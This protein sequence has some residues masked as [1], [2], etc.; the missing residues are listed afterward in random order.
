MFTA[1]VLLAS[2]IT[3]QN[4]PRVQ[5]T[6]FSIEIPQKYSRQVSTKNIFLSNSVGMSSTRIGFT[7]EGKVADPV[8]FQERLWAKQ[9][10]GWSATDV[11]PDT[12]LEIG[13]AVLLHRSGTLTLRDAKRFESTLVL[14]TPDGSISA[15]VTATDAQRGVEGLA[16][17]IQ[18]LRTVQTES[19]AIATGKPSK[20]TS[21]TNS[22][23]NSGSTSTSSSN[24][25]PPTTK[26]T[27][28]KPPRT[29]PPSSPAKDVFPLVTPDEVARNARLNQIAE[30]LYPT[31]PTSLTETK[32]SALLQ[33]AVELCGFTVRNPDWQ[34]VKNP[35]KEQAIGLAV[36]T[37][38]IP[39]VATLFTQG[40]TVNYSDWTAALDQSWSKVVPNFKSGE[41]MTDFMHSGRLHPSAGYR[42]LRQFIRQLSVQSMNGVLV[43]DDNAKLDA[44]QLF[45]LTRLVTEVVLH[46]LRT[47][48]EKAKTLE[49]P[50][51]H[52]QLLASNASFTITQ[53]G[54]FSGWT[55]D[56]AS[57]ASGQY[58]N[59]V[60]DMVIETLDPLNGADKIDKLGNFADAAGAIGSIIKFICSYA[61]LTG[62]LKVLPPGNPLTRRIEGDGGEERTMQAKFMIDGS[63][64]QDFLKENRLILNSITGGTLDFDSPKTSPI[65][66][67]HQWEIEQDRFSS[68]N[69]AVTAVRGTGDFSK[70]QTDENGIT[71]L[72][73]E[74]ARRR[75]PLD[76]R[77]LIPYIRRVRVIVTPQIKE[78][79]MRQDLLDAFTTS[80]GIRGLTPG[81]VS[82]GQGG[83]NA[84]ISAMNAIF[85][86]L[87]RMNWAG[88]RYV[89]LEVKDYIEANAIATVKINFK[90]D[91][92]YQE[93]QFSYH[94]AGS[95]K[96]ESNAMLMG[97]TDFEG[98]GGYP[99][100]FTEEMLKQ[101]PPDMRAQIQAEIEKWRKEQSNPDQASLIATYLGGGEL[102]TSLNHTQDVNGVEGDGEGDSG[103]NFSA[104]QETSLNPKKPVDQNTSN[105]SLI[106]SLFKK[107]NEAEV[108]FDFGEQGIFKSRRS[109][110]GNFPPVS[111]PK[112]VSWRTNLD[113]EGS[114]NPFKTSLTTKK[115]SE[116]TTIYE[117]FV[118]R[119]LLFN[120]ERI[121]R[122]NFDW[123]LEIKDPTPQK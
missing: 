26:P 41:Y 40:A 118:S 120:K 114:S 112:G 31:D 42:S 75:K 19:G 56:F 111:E 32:A 4:N 18:M 109:G 104:N 115:S 95:G 78:T 119:H 38:D 59:K 62:E 58:F 33:E 22:S 14:T 34:I 92:S 110:R 99:P 107:K 5:A 46:P 105:T 49:E 20:T 28:T 30:A 12:K 48:V 35:P 71:K 91:H 52:P 117:G 21:G 88:G 116:G 81:K 90:Y 84:L 3:A 55:E 70:L 100:G 121:G 79:E 97:I 93:V 16:D 108:S 43:S 24:T 67:R 25:N 106:I 47:E 64:I 39:R 63:K 80:S 86:T 76:R 53:A 60:R 51:T 13:S 44:I 65:T 11:T 68:D 98:T 102:Q 123:K 2:L 57:Y 66:G 8:A 54:A 77:L 36:E 73:V 96:L 23:G 6:S 15:T 74:G 27:D 7:F 29:T 89:I 85:E 122:V 1:T 113:I 61:Y 83:P 9:A 103:E 10:S 72:T 82:A 94:T 17:T 101:L 37:S 87:Y 50:Q 45:L 69:L